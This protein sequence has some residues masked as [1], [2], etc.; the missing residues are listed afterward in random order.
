MVHKGVDKD[1]T[2]CDRGT[3]WTFAKIASITKASLLLEKKMSQDRYGVINESILGS[4]IDLWHQFDVRHLIL[5]QVLQSR[6][7]S[8][9]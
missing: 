3:S 2:R 1:M 6:I 4:K 7:K 8:I 9:D 5:C